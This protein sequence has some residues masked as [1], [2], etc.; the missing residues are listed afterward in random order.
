MRRVGLHGSFFGDNFGDTLFAVLTK[1]VLR[2]CNVE[3]VLP[4]ASNRVLS[5][6][7]GAHSSV[8]GFFRC[9]KLIF[10]GGGYL[11]EPARGLS[12]WH[13]RFFIRH[14]WLMLLARMLKKEYLVVGVGV[15]PLSF[16]PTR[17]LVTWFL[18]GA[19]EVWARDEKSLSFLRSDL[20][21]KRGRL[22]SD[23][24]VHFISDRVNTQRSNR[25]SPPD[26]IIGLHLPM[27]RKSEMVT[28]LCERL[29]RLDGNYSFVYFQDFHKPSFVSESLA[30]IRASKIEFTVHEYNSVEDMLNL[31]GS[32]GAL[33]TVK[34]H[35]GIVAT[36]LGIPTL[37]LS[38]HEKTQR[39]FRQIGYSGLNSPHDENGDEATEQ[40]LEMVQHDEKVVIPSTVLRQSEDAIQAIKDFVGP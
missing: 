5:Q 39:Y 8:L 40:F 24:V 6:L 18:N 15:G 28:K 20:G 2:D 34:L 17:L 35:V 22:C 38:V 12:F 19:C 23:L 30:E 7:G 3:L 21:V 36:T 10:T 33:V 9:E 25:S 4:A 13:L 29:K 1:D 14:G 37:S 31:I 32:L 16:L 11:G 27:L 26:K